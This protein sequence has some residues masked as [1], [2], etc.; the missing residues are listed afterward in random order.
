MA[1]RFW[2]TFWR[3]ARSS[4]D[5]SSRSLPS[6]V[7][8]LFSFDSTSPRSGIDFARTSSRGK[9]SARRMASRMA[10]VARAARTTSH[11]SSSSSTVSAASIDATSTSPASGKSP[12]PWKNRSMSARSPCAA[13]HALR[14]ASGRR[15]RMAL[16]PRELFASMAMSVSTRSSSSC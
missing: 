1:V 12:S 8:Y 6:L 11:D 7:K 5:A 14:L 3:M 9:S 16:L 13:S 2:W 10:C 4:A 15:P